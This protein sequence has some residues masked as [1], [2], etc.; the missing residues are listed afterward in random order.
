MMCC[1]NA[2]R[3]FKYTIF[4]LTAKHKKYESVESDLKYNYRYYEIIFSGNID[5]D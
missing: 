2:L 5:S 4:V 1:N 3:S